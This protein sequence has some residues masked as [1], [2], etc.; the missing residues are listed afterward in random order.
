MTEPYRATNPS[1]RPTRREKEYLLISVSIQTDKNILKKL[2]VVN[3]KDLLTE[4]QRMW[5]A[6]RD[7]SN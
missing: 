7:T 4:V 6:K 2:K 1:Y 5:K 3:Y